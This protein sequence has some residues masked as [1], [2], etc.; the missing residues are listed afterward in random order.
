MVGPSG[1]T[2]IFCDP[3]PRASPWAGGMAAPLGLKL[4]GDKTRDNSATNSA[5]YAFG[6]ASSAHYPVWILDSITVEESTVLRSANDAKDIAPE[7]MFDRLAAHRPSVERQLPD[8]RPALRH[9]RVA[10]VVFL[11]L[12]GKTRHSDRPV[13]IFVHGV[14]L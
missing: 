11:A 3:F 4:R 9:R 6:L 7:L 13:G 5:T 12:I 8:H 14:A 2:D 1:R 10:Q